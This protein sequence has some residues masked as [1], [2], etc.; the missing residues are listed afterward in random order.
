[1]GSQDTQYTYLP[2]RAAILAL[3]DLSLL[4]CCGSPRPVCVT[5]GKDMGQ[6]IYACDCV[7]GNKTFG[8]CNIECPIDP[9]IAITQFKVSLAVSIYM[10][11]IWL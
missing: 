7:Y 4:V 8:V 2:L 6:L 11:S 1:M 3:L 9:N 5:V 10:V